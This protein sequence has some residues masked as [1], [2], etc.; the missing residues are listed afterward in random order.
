MAQ[1]GRASL[2][3]YIQDLFSFTQRSVNC[4]I[5]IISTMKLLCVRLNLYCP[6][7]VILNFIVLWAQC[8]SLA[9]SDHGVF[10]L[11]CGHSSHTLIHHPM[12]L[13]L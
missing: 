10:V 3:V 11:C 8:S 6:G 7:V 9:D 4:L 12:I 2:L 13:H 1:T 5:F